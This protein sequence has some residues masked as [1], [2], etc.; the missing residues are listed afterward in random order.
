MRTD[1]L[2]YQ[3]FLQ[4]PQLLFALIGE[5]TAKSSEYA[6]H[7]VELKETAFRIDGVF[8]PQMA[9]G[10]VYFLELQFQRDAQFYSRLFSEIFLYFRQFPLPEDWRAVVVFAQKAHDN[11]LPNAYSDLAARLQII[12]LDTLPD[13]V[14]ARHPL[15]I[16]QLLTL[17]EDIALVQSKARMAIERANTSAA[18]KSITIDLITKIL[19]EK[20]DHI[21]FEEAHAMISAT[22]SDIEK[23]N[24]YIGLREKFRVEGKIEGKI[25][26]IQETTRNHIHAMYRSGLSTETI[27]H[28]TN[29]TIAEVQALK[30]SDVK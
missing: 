10:T 9:D 6:F 16:L 28:I 26:G 30:P 11:G 2:L 5:D 8:S 22:L 14:F 18:Q 15:D 13:D 25:E 20:F 21:S 29:L 24:F 12:H 17:P 1:T 4:L 23:S 27:A 7:S 19:V 3:L